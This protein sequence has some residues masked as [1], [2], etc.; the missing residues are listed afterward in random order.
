M[1]E[2]KFDGT[3]RDKVKAK[4]EINGRNHTVELSKAMFNELTLELFQKTLTMTRALLDKNGLGTIDKII[5]VGGSSNMPQVIEGLRKAFVGKEIQ[6][7]K[8]ET[9]VAIGAAIYAQFCAP[10]RKLVPFT[11]DRVLRFTNAL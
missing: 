9:A 1:S 7:Y 8:P 5:C 6:V 3:Y 4:I 11:K 10:D 2:K